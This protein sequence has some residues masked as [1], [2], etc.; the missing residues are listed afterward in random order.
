MPVEI[1]LNNVLL[2]VFLDCRLSPT[3]TTAR[4]C[5]VGNWISNLAAAS[6]R[7]YCCWFCWSRNLHTALRCSIIYC[8]HTLCFSSLPVQVRA[9]T[10]SGHFTAQQQYVDLIKPKARRFLLKYKVVIFSS[11]ALREEYRLAVFRNRVLKRMWNWQGLEN[12]SCNGE[13]RDLCFSADVGGNMRVGEKCSTHGWDKKLQRVLVGKLNGKC[14][15]GV[16][17]DDMLIWILS[18]KTEFALRR[19][20]RCTIGSQGPFL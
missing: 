18:L 16:N 10:K 5:T 20:R 7:F 15:R 14:H 3:S 4:C 12:V 8:P 17:W 19:C 2:H 1:N 13:L 9:Y 6:R 11:L